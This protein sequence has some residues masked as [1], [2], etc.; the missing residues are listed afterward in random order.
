MVPHA[1]WNFDWKPPTDVFIDSQPISMLIGKRS[2]LRRN[3]M[4]ELSLVDTFNLLV[5]TIPSKS[6]TWNWFINVWFCRYRRRFRGI[7]RQ[8]PRPHGWTWCPP[9]PDVDVHISSA[10]SDPRRPDRRTYAWNNKILFEH[11]FKHLPRSYAEDWIPRGRRR[12]FL[13]STFRLN[14]VR[15]L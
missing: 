4:D 11:M 14:H 3:E 9:G 5:A 1:G 12:L 13:Y 6:I 10:G 2:A 15:D 7:A 8:P